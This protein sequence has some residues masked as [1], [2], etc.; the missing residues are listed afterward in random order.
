MLQAQAKTEPLL[1]DSDLENYRR[2][3]QA[4]IKGIKNS[5]PKDKPPIKISVEQSFNIS[6][7]FKELCS[8]EKDRS[9]LFR[10]LDAKIKRIEGEEHKNTNMEAWRLIPDWEIKFVNTQGFVLKNKKK[11]RDLLAVDEGGP[12]RE[13]FTQIWKNMEFLKIKYKNKENQ[14]KFFKLFETSEAGPLPAKDELFEELGEKHSEEVRTFVEEKARKY[15]R[16]LGRIMFRVIVSGHTFP[17]EA[18]PTFFRNGESLLLITA[19]PA[20]I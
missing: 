7:L 20:E 9:Y 19:I 4:F 10:G 18:M 15:Y 13:F 5:A 11:N 2:L 8:K 14:T 1:T 6:T 3:Y 16:A 17:V 12:T